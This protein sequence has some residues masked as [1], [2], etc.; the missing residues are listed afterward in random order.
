[1]N[2]IFLFVPIIELKNV[3]DLLCVAACVRDDLNPNL[4][5]YALSVALLHRSDTKNLNLP[6]NVQIF[7]GN[8]IDSKVFPKLLEEASNFPIGCREPIIIPQTASDLEP[9]HR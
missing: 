8:Y 1:M 3:D 4:F 5:N 2:T 7:P 9:E 6:N